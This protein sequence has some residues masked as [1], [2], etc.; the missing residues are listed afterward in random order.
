VLVIVYSVVRTSVMTSYHW[1]ILVHRQRL[2]PE[3]LMIS[4]YTSSAGLT[5]AD[6]CLNLSYIS[7]IFGFINKFLLKFN[8]CYVVALKC[9]CYIF[10]AHFSSSNKHAAVCYFCAWW[11]SSSCVWVRWMR[12][13]Q[14]MLPLRD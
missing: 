6:R 12:S 5:E 8:I 1:K 7:R 2:S 10:E 13:T 9:W 11:M 14:F 3:H 4:C